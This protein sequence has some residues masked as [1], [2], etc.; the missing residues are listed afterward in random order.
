MRDVLPAIWIY[1]SKMAE[2]GMNNGAKKG[3]GLQ[4]AKDERLHLYRKPPFERLHF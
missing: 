4:K 3:C 2:I 1:V